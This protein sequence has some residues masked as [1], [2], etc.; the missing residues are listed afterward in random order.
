ML[1][2]LVE[3]RG[4]LIFAVAAAAKIRD[5]GRIG[6]GRGV[7]SRRSFVGPVAVGARG[8]AGIA[9]RVHFAVHA[10]LVLPDFLKMTN[11]AID[12]FG[13]CLAGPG[14]VDRYSRMALAAGNFGVVR[15]KNIRLVDGQRMSVFG[16]MNVFFAVTAHAIAVR[17]PLIIKDFADLMGLMTIYANGNALRVF[18]PK[19]SVDDFAVDSGDID[20][21]LHAGL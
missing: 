3:N 10:L 4:F 5:I 8:G 16:R 19:F 11:T 1:L 13:D 20:M 15:V 12:F 14:F 17:G 21:T 2:A 7:L 9:L 18:L 6:R